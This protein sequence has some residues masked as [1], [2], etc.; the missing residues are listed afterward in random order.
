[1]TEV[2]P[3]VYI[4]LA[5]RGLSRGPSE[6]SVAARELLAGGMWELVP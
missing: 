4:P 6:S 2:T 5:T 1:M 3:L